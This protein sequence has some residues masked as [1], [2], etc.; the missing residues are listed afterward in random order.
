MA[1]VSSLRPVDVTV[2]SS[3]LDVLDLRVHFPTE[4]GIVKSVDGVSF[5]LAKGSTLGI[6]GA[7]GSG[8]GVPPLALL[9]LHEGTRA[10]VSGEIRLD[11]RDLVALP[12]HDMRALRGRTVS[13]IF[14]DPL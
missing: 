4:D 11:G 3:F 5:T 9:G 1:L 10:V 14:Q 7:S 8:K 12:E 2:P 6:V 13:M